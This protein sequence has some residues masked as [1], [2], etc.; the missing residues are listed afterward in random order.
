MNK[1]DQSNT[2]RVRILGE[3]H[4]IRGEASAEYINQIGSILDTKLRE[5]QKSHPN[6]TRYHMVILAAFNLADELE[7][8]KA[9]YK[10]LL[11]IMEDVN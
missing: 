10:E 4:S 1:N 6:L 2:V 8:I 9:E 3:E 5:V 11:Q 7:K